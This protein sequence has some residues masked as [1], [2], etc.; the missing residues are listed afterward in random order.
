[1]VNLLNYLNFDKSFEVKYI[2][3]IAVIKCNDKLNIHNVSFLAK[4]VDSLISQ[5]K[6]SILVD[7]KD[8]L[9]VDS[10]GLGILFV[11]M[12]R[13]KKI[14]ISFKLIGLTEFVHKLFIRS[15]IESLFEV[16][17][18]EEAAIGSLEN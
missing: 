12:N 5:N 16:Y 3:D 18:N 7:M 13:L 17:E 10:T 8:L 11:T 14:N 9:Y 6:G 2:N 15:D 4:I 1:M